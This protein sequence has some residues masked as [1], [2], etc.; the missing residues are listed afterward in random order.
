MKD[1][2]NYRRASELYPLYKNDLDRHLFVFTVPGMKARRRSDSRDL[3]DRV[4]EWVQSG[5]TRWKAAAES[6]SLH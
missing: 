2:R 4:R 1:A 6:V 5:W 3:G